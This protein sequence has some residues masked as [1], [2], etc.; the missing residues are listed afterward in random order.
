MTLGS[1]E[2]GHLALGALASLIFL[3]QSLG[4]A[5]SGADIDADFDSGTDMDIDTDIDAADYGG[6]SH[7]LS[8]TSL[9]DYLSVRNFVAF[10]IGY[11]WVTLAGLYSG[12]SRLTSSIGGTAA[13]LAFVFVSLVLVRT[14]LKFQEDGSLKLDTL[15]GFTAS[16][17]IT[18]GASSSATGKVMV[19]TKTGRAELPARTRDAETLR[20]GTVVLITGAEGGILLVSRKEK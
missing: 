2:W 5:H 6:H 9:S 1:W 14:F 15:T 19:D 10:F 20:P 4:S 18:V 3:F 12:F 16:V 8:G 17:Y 7:G 13:G 11:G